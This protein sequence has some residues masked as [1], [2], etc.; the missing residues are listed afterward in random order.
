M[1]HMTFSFPFVYDNHMGMEYECIARVEAGQIVEI[2]Y[3]GWDPT[4]KAQ[5]RVERLADELLADAFA[6]EAGDRADRLYDQMRD[7]AMTGDRE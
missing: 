3:I 5:D 2:D 7:D 1:K 4:P 6:E